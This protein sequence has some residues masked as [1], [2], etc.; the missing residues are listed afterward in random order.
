MNAPVKAAFD[1][2]LQEATDAHDRQDWLG[3]IDCWKALVDLDPG[4]V[5]GYWLGGGLLLAY[6]RIE[7]AEAMLSKGAALDP[8]H[9]PLGVNHAMAATL[10]QNWPEAVLRWNALNRRAPD[11]P[12]VIAGRA[13]AEMHIQ[14]HR[15]DEE[16]EGGSADIDW[17][18]FEAGRVSSADADLFSHFQ[19]VG[20]NCEFGLVQRHFRA[21]PVSLL[22]WAGI[23]LDALINGLDKRFVGLGD[24]EHTELKVVHN[25]YLL[26]DLLYS[27]GMHTFLKPEM[28]RE[29][30]EELHRKMC[31]RQAFLGRKFIEDLE[32][33]E[34]IFVFK[35][36]KETSAERA[37][38]LHAAM[39]RYGPATLLFA[40]EAGAR[41]AGSVEEIQP[42]LFLGAIDRF[43][44][45][46]KGWDHLHWD[47][48]RAVCDEVLRRVEKP[49][50]E[51]GFFERIFQK[52][53]G[54][55]RV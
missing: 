25:E 38:A 52:T 21:E 22:R 31:R 16:A 47:T 32:D 49:K 36:F 44:H 54:Q 8:S 30:P 18:R 10:L 15:L 28:T 46:G 13:E 5:T 20:D 50:P 2:T 41:P 29:T 4:Y 37:K 26:D 43:S 24:P 7:E 12:D 39:R 42:G 53:R 14:L 48:W 45:P 33:P 11:D 34:H 40:V 27:T 1:R 19:S 17:R 51:L 9:I 3:A 55:S 35:S 23:S 6:G